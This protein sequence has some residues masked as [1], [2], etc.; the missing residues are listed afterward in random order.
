MDE[1]KPLVSSDSGGQGS[2]EARFADFCKSG[3]SLPEKTCAEAMKLFTESKHLLS[4]SVSAI[5]T[6]TSE[7][8]ERYWFAFV[9]Y[10]VRRLSESNMDDSSQGNG[11]NGFT[12]CQILRL[13]KLN[14][15]DFFQG[16]SS[17]HYQ[18]W[19]NFK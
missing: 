12:L 4:T 10:S 2:V 9:L 18:V 6:G 14:I 1:L 15:V 17:V 7:E 8:A 5:G 11:Q 3:L 16:T 13:A 19:S